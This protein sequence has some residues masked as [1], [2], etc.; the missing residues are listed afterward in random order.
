MRYSGS[1]STEGT[2]VRIPQHKTDS[3]LF[4]RDESLSLAYIFIL[5]GPPAVVVGHD[6]ERI[7]MG[8]RKCFPFFLSK[9]WC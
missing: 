1:S 8:P 2:A 3:D 6:E 5:P 7:Q 9:G 4:R